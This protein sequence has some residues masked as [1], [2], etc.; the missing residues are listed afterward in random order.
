MPGVRNQFLVFR[1]S[2]LLLLLA[3][4]FLEKEGSNDRGDSGA[5]GRFSYDPIRQPADG[6]TGLT[7]GASSRNA[8]CARNFRTAAQSV[9]AAVSGSARSPAGS[10]SLFA[11]SHLPIPPKAPRRP[12]WAAPCAT[13]L[14]IGRHSSTKTKAALAPRN[15]GKRG[16]RG[17]VFAIGV[18]AFLSSERIA[19]GEELA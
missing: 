3:I 9:P 16:E 8:G 11:G 10:M 6:V 18:Y 5:G 4:S 1:S 12:G 7:K 2:C 17:S 14:V 15:Q 13:A 19:C